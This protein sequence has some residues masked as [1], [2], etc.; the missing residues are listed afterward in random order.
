MR[1]TALGSAGEPLRTRVYYSVGGGF[2][3][4]DGAAEPPPAGGRRLAAAPPFPFHTGA[5]L[6]RLCSAHGL[7]M[8]DV[9][10]DERDDAARGA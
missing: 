8:S 9:M 3:V 2:V 4:D 7:R 6:L 5:D 1:F 10:L